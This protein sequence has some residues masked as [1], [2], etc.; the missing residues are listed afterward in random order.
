MKQSLK[1]KVATIRGKMLDL[2]DELQERVYELEWRDDPEGK[3]AEE[4]SEIEQLIEYLD[5][6]NMNIEEFE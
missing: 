3:W 1:N 2:I 5:E 4:I 6:A